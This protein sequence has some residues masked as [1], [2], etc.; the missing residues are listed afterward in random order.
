MCGVIL[1]LGFGDSTQPTARGDR[2][3]TDNLCTVR[4]NAVLGCLAAC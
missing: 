3:L 2:T 4:T 1:L